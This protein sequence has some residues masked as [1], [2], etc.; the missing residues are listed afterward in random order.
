[1]EALQDEVL[2]I[3]SNAFVP[4]GEAESCEFPP[5]CMTLCWG[6]GLG[7]SV[8]QPFLPSSMWIFSSPHRSYSNNFWVFFH[9]NCSMCSCRFAESMAGSEF[10]SLLF[11]HLGTELCH[12]FHYFLILSSNLFPHS[13]PHLSVWNLTALGA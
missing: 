6:C 8:F 9:G 13:N 4:Q 3:G 2:D 7:E 12:S 5:D 10:R 11:H 1:M